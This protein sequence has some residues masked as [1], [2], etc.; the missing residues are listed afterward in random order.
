MNE[1]H[2]IVARLIA[3]ATDAKAIVEAL[4]PSS[5]SSWHVFASIWR[6]SV[7]APPMHK[8]SWQ[9]L[10]TSAPSHRSSHE[11]SGGASAMHA[12]SVHAAPSAWQV[13]VL[14]PSENDLTPVEQL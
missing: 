4:S 7:L 12:R 11:P 8:H 1:F 10:T 9:P 3:T 13:H 2:S 6:H 5:W 14:Q